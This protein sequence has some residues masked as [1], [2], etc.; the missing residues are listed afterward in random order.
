M[1]AYTRY[2]LSVL[3]LCLCAGEVGRGAQ[4]DELKPA[5]STVMPSK[6]DSHNGVAVWSGGALVFVQDRFSS[7]PIFRI[8]DRDGSELSRFDFRMLGAGRINI[9]DNSVARGLDGALTIVGTADFDD[10]QGGMFVAWVSPDGR[11]QTVMRTYPFLP[12]AVTVASDGTIWVVGHETDAHGNLDYSKA[13]VR[14]YDKSGK[15][16]GSF[17]PWSSLATEPN[18]ATG[19]LTLPFVESVLLPLGDRVSW[20]LPNARTYIEFGLNGSIIQQYK[21]APTEDNEPVYFSACEDSSVFASSQIHEVGQRRWTIF[22]LDRQTGNWKLVRKDGNWGMS[23]GCDG[24][25][26]ATTSDFLTI[27]WL[28]TAAK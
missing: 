27:S 4:A 20:Y 9:Y 23:L 24:T 5:G 1:S 19:P 3:L 6:I 18:S 7:A 16:L 12:A 10:S 13:L 22:R 15:L 17:V 25:R 14:R 21:A 2:F 11:R 28:E 26:L 8:V